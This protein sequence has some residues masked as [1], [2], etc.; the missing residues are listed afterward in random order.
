MTN[1]VDDIVN[2]AILEAKVR[3]RGPGRRRLPSST[4]RLMKEFYKD[5]VPKSEIAK[6]L[7][8]SR[9]TIDDWLV[10]NAYDN[11]REKAAERKKKNMPEQCELCGSAAN[12]CYHS[13]FRGLGVWLCRSCRWLAGVIDKHDNARELMNA[14]EK[15]KREAAASYSW[16]TEDE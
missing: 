2:E 10:P 8:V 3:R 14:Y 6:R 5:G 4:I 1:K 13:W 9:V 12:L 11:R 7:K 16:R 15:L